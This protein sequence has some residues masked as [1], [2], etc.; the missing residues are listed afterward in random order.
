M[1]PFSIT[2]GRRG[3]L[4]GIVDHWVGVNQRSAAVF[5]GQQGQKLGP[6]EPPHRPAKRAS[7]AG[8]ELSFSDLRYKHEA[9]YDSDEQ[10]VESESESSF[11]CCNDQATLC[12]E[13]TGEL[14]Q[15]TGHSSGT[16][17]L[18]ASFADGKKLSSFSDAKQQ[19]PSKE[20]AHTVFEQLPMPQLRRRVSAPPIL[21]LTV[22]TPSPTTSKGIFSSV[23]TADDVDVL[24]SSEDSSIVSVTVEERGQQAQ[25]SSTSTN[26]SVVEPALSSTAAAAPESAESTSDGVAAPTAIPALP[27]RQLRFNPKTRVYLHLH[28]DDYTDAEFEASYLT[29]EDLTRIQLD[30][31]QSIHQMRVNTANGHHGIVHVDDAD[32]EEDESLEEEHCSR[33]LE[34]MASPTVAEAHRVTK[35]AVRDAVMDEQDRQFMAEVYHE[36]RIATTSISASA[37]SVMEA[38]L[39]GASDAVY[40]QR[41]VRTDAEDDTGI[42]QEE[43]H[44]EAGEDE[45]T[46]GPPQDE[47]EDTAVSEVPLAPAAADD[48]ENLSSIL[49]DA[50]N[51][52]M[53]DNVQA[54]DSEQHNEG[55]R[56]DPSSL[57]R[58]GSRERLLDIL[59]QLRSD[60]AQART[61]FQEVTQVV[62]GDSRRSSSSDE[63]SHSASSSSSS[64]EDGNIRPILY[65]YFCGDLCC[66][67]SFCIYLNNAKYY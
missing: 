34:S 59:G 63:A 18:A 12:T 9:E 48:N 26:T 21:G 10:S 22:E 1:P 6:A 15:T 62:R 35:A 32:I 45:E 13:K 27:R 58:V 23:P 24:V 31:V 25:T 3:R 30:A 14:T 2:S 37:D 53:H 52:S 39:R 66:T 7:Y 64:A 65:L 16:T 49:Q 51:V 36:D 29:D 61:E 5:D 33:G 19:E 41:F 60:M 20:E 28:L 67:I 46:T 11:D 8:H 54:P 17:T 38:I 4:Q 57:T 55:P 42:A 50:L 40:V 56:P 43:A 44:A 47:A